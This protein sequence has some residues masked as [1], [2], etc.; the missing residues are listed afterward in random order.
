M[1]RRQ[2]TEH[3]RRC[4]HVML[5]GTREERLRLQWDLTGSLYSSLEL[6]QIRD[7]V[8]QELRATIAPVRHREHAP[9]VDLD[10]AG[11]PPVRLRASF[12]SHAPKDHAFECGE[13]GT[14][15]QQAIGC[16]VCDRIR[17]EAC[18]SGHC[19]GELTLDDVG[20][21][22]GVSKERVRQIES[23]ALRK[24][25]E[26]LRALERGARR[27]I[28]RDADR[29]PLTDEQRHQKAALQVERLFAQ[30]AARKAEEIRGVQQIAAQLGERVAARYALNRGLSLDDIHA[31][32]C[33][34][35]S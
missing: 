22:I 18:D 3:Q 34:E 1:M 23:R 20:R 25:R 6:K 32:F 24:M 8:W 13:C 2:T 16:G 9:Y 30:R 10:T 5:W 33:R 19:H 29:V 35:A 17:C 21:V 15:V 7:D 27:R 4:L 28:A 14:E 11:A 26:R 12:R 31:L